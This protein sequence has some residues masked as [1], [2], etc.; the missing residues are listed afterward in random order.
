MAYLKIFVCFRVWIAAVHQLSREDYN[1]IIV[2]K[3][4]DF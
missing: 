2:M 4:V 3:A 1:C